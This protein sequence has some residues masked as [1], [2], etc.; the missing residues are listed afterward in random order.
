ML[1]A[2]I[3]F[4]LN[5][6]MGVTNRI[7]QSWRNHFKPC[8]PWL[9]ITDLKD[10]KKQ[11]ARSGLKV[12]VAEIVEKLKKYEDFYSHDKQKKANNEQKFEVYKKKMEELDD[13]LTQL[14]EVTEAFDEIC[15]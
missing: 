9:Q 12:I 14:G 6:S 2:L 8:F 1:S 5:I 7:K 10:E 3:E 13:R 15:K 11:K 4:H